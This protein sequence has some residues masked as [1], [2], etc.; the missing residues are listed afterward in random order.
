MKTEQYMYNA[1]NLYLA[2]I[3]KIF[4]KFRKAAGY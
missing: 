2:K 3:W 4:K 1:K